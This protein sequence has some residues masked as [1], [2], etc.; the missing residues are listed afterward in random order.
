MEGTVL[1]ADDDKSIRTVLTQAFVRSGCKVKST[2][3]THTLS[4]WIEEGEGDI[5]LSD[6]MMPDGEVFDMLHHFSK[7]RPNLP[8]ILMSAQNNVLTA[9]KANKL[10][11]YE[12]FPKPFDLREVLS[13]ANGAL[14]NTQSYNS[15]VPDKLSNVQTGTFENVLPI[16]GRSLPMQDIYKIMARLMRTDLTVMISGASGTGKELVA[17]AL[18][19][20]GL[21]K[22]KKFVKVNLAAMPSDSLELELF[23]SQNEIDETQVQIGKFEL[24]SGGT[25]LLD[26]VGDLPINVQ[27]RL[28]SFL[29]DGFFSRLGSSRLVKANVRIIATSQYDLYDLIDERKFREDLFYRLNVVPIKLPELKERADDILDLCN[30]FLRLGAENASE[31]KSI[32]S[33]SVRLLKQQAWPGNIR[34]LKNFIDR[35][36]VLS[37]DKVIEA[38]LISKEI[39]SLPKQLEPFTK[40]QTERLA[41]TVGQHLK[42]YFDLHGESLPPPGLYDRFMKEI[43]APLI[44]YALKATKGNQLKTAE[45]LGI[46]RNTLRKKIK[47]LDITVS[48]AKEIL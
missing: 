18:H 35:V 48:R 8:I 36:A 42:R 28:L 17:K 12:Y 40:K 46:N 9:I 3:L 6:I 39:N 23:G 4:K 24:A 7:L 38:D 11:A 22:N 15:L 21:R 33:E 27:G 13:I 31:I 10:G 20:F 41:I 1:I 43:E 37:P 25:L 34:E 14:K 26:E 16:I 30:H 29:Q 5:V 19:D 2:G 47:D 32:S 44:S 45:L